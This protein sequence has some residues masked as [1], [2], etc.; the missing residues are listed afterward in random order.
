MAIFCS[1]QGDGMG[2]PIFI[3]T[4]FSINIRK[5]VKIFNISGVS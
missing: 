5:G 2:D 1:W 3:L 4:N